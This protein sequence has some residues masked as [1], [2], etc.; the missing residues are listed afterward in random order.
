MAKRIYDNILDTFGNTPLVKL[1]R[2]TEGAVANVYAKL[3]FYNPAASVKDRLAISVVDHAEAAGLLKPGGTIVEASSG[4]TG[5]GL[6]LVGA[7][8]GYKVIITIPENLN[9]ERRQLIRGYG[10]EVVLTPV[11][12][13][14]RGAVEK[15]L[16]IVGSTPGAI[17]ADQFKTEANIA[18]HRK[19]TAEEVWNDTEGEVDIFVAGVGTGGT[20]SGVGQVLKERKPSVHIVAVEP[21]ESPLLSGGQP[22]PHKIPGIGAN[23]IPEVV[24]RNVIDEVITVLSEDAAATAR[25]IS[26]QEGILAG[27]SGGAAVTAALEL[28]KRPENAGKNIVVVIPDYGERYLST[29]LFEHTRD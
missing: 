28:A 24:D 5:I 11:G 22:G 9:I 26:Q 3:E 7:A 23:F 15:A 8:R 4:N 14:M 19:T 2:V 10:A 1:N 21:T 13:G 17:L 29:Y 18:I 27:I 16:E 25:K 20:V 6:A 12:E